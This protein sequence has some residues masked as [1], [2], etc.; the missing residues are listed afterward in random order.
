MPSFALLFF[1]GMGNV[2]GKKG[3]MLFI[4]L[5]RIFLSCFGEN[6]LDK[7]ASVFRAIVNR[8]RVYP[9]LAGLAA[10]ILARRLY[11]GLDCRPSPGRTIRGKIQGLSVT[12]IRKLF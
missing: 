7:A 8:S 2:V 3:V 1:S 4:Q 11:G 10:V 9:P 12:P 6:P 5:H